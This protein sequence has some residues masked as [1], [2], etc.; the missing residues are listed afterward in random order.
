MKTDPEMFHLIRLKYALAL[1]I[2]S[3]HHSR[4]SV[5]AHVKRVFNL[6]GSKPSVYAQLVTIIDTEVK[7]R[8]AKLAASEP[9]AVGDGRG[10]TTG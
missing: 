8:E 9:A 10:T 1:E 4:G 7:Q 2:K 6:R 3:M 5:Y